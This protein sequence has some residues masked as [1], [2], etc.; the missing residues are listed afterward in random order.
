[1]VHQ[2]NL[3]LIMKTKLNAFVLSMALLIQPIAYAGFDEW[4]VNTFPYKESDFY[5]KASPSHVY[6]VRTAQAASIHSYYVVG[7]D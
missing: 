5:L 6:A 4:S 1:V 2:N 7:H 3:E